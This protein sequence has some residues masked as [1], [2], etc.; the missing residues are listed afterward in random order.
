MRKY[1]IP[2][3]FAAFTKSVA[4]TVYPFQNELSLFAR[5]PVRA[6][7]RHARHGGR[8]DRE[9]HKILRLEIVQMTLAAG[10]R[11][12]LSFKRQH[13]EIIGKAPAAKN[14]IKPR[15]EHWVLRG[16]AGG[17]AALVP[18]V[19]AAGRGAEL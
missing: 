16:D 5:N 8:L 14:G 7:D 4:M 10:A 15:G 9:R 11:D 2:R 6:G 19:V 18:V 3:S 17:I 1:L 12:G 13:G